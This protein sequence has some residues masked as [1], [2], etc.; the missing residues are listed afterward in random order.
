VSRDLD[1][2]LKSLI[3]RTEI[4]R[5]GP[6]DKKPQLTGLQRYEKHSPLSEWAIMNVSHIKERNL[7]GTPA[8]LVS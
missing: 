8:F 3:A 1:V 5:V 7:F 6:T 2:S 4:R